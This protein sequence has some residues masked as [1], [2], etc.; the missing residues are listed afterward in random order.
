VA[1]DFG[2]QP[3]ATFYNDLIEKGEAAIKAVLEGADTGI[4]AAQILTSFSTQR[5]TKGRAS[6]IIN[7]LGG[8]EDGHN[9]GNERLSWVV[10]VES[11][12]DDVKDEETTEENGAARARHRDYCAKV[13]DALKAPGLHTALSAAVEEFTVFDSIQR[14]RGPSRLVKRKFQSEF[15][16]E[17]SCAPSAIAAS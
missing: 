13:F 4:D 1:T 8:Q 12:A 17:F 15:R 11:N 9:S 10:S 3:V 16:L 6:I 14:S 2:R 5:E 7:G